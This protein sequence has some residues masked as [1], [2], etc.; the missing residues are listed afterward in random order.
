MRDSRDLG[1]DG[2]PD[3]VLKKLYYDHTGE[4]AQFQREYFENQQE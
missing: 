4:Y 1:E 2:E 3:D